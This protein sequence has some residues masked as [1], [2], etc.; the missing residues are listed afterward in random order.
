MKP[1]LDKPVRNIFRISKHAGRRYYERV[2]GGEAD[3]FPADL[4]G[5]MLR[6]I[7]SAK[8]RK[9]YLSLPRFILWLYKK[10]GGV[11]GLAIFESE[12]VCYITKKEKGNNYRLIVTCWKKEPGVPFGPSGIWNEAGLSSKEIWVKIAQYKA[13]LK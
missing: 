4:Y 2:D 3:I 9:D 6:D 12:N 11:N 10:Y 13:G 8:E 1:L 7:S 5:R